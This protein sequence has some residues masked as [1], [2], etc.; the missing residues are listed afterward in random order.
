MI[1]LHIVAGSVALLAAVV[2]LAVTKGGSLHRRSGTAYVVAML[3][4]GLSGAGIAAT[5]GVTISVIAGLLAAYLVTTGWLTVRLPVERMR[6]VLLVGLLVALGIGIAG[7]HFGVRALAAPAAGLTPETSGVPHLV[8][9]SLALL[10]AALDARLL[11]VGHIAGRQR[12]ARHLWRLLV[13]LVMANAAFFLGQAD[14]FPAV[15][16]QP[17]L[18]AL[19][20]LASLLLIPYW[21]LR[22]LRGRGRGFPSARAQAGGA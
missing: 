18:L 10:G 7:L 14:E 2:A 9:G 5:R 8:F 3:V 4:M 21:L 20:V 19:P 13:A 12:L 16:R 6:A 1:V 17:F 11:K 22:V 15:L